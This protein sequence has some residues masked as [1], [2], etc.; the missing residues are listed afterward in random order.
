MASKAATAAWLF[1]AALYPVW[2]LLSILGWFERPQLGLSATPGPGGEMVITAV[3]PGG[4]AWESGARSG[5]I[6]LEIEGVEVDAVRWSSGGD[7][8]TEF[9]VMRARDGT[10]ISESLQP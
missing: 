1:L 10:L 2:A 6:L 9:R 8:G 5:D 3:H 4:L 7:S